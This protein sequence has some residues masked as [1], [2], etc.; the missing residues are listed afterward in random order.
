M[1]LNFN[2]EKQF[3]KSKN[4]NSNFISS[5]RATKTLIGLLMLKKNFYTKKKKTSKLF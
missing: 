1:N 3:K 2:L 4:L 5:Q